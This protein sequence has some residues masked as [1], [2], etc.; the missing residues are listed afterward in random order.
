VPGRPGA[1]PA[2]SVAETL[3]RVVASVLGG[4]AAR[5]GARPTLPD[6]VRGR[7]PRPAGR[8]T[9]AGCKAS[10]FESMDQLDSFEYWTREFGTDLAAL[11]C[12]ALMIVAY[13]V[14]LWARTR[15]DASYSIHVVNDLARKLW[16]ES[17]MLEDG[18]DVM[19]V[20]SLRNFIMFGI[21]MVSTT[22]LLIIG[23]LTLSG[24][25]D[26]LA[27]SWHALN[28]LGSRSRE[29]LVVKILFLLA[30]FMVA[31]F[32]FMLSIR[33]ANHVL[34]MI[35]IPAQRRGAHAAL[36][37]EHVVNRLNRA[38]RLLSVGMRAYFF[39][40][41][42]VFWLFGPAFLV[43]STVGLVI[44]LSRVDRHQAHL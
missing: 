35:N 32:S 28:S 43:L 17:V 30:D 8:G 26:V 12:S 36:A 33:L 10:D 1:N 19:A 40:V 29:L 13:Y 2:G 23:T 14:V 20:Q 25:E 44:V 18:R 21:L 22:V 31:F 9:R 24:Q 3:L 5:R 16:V 37:P 38:G 39:A 27:R 11:A 41:P 4:G 6:A 42:L 15:R 34:F 7:L